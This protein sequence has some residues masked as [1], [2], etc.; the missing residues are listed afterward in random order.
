[1]KNTFLSLTVL[2]LTATGSCP[3]DTIEL[4]NG[5]FIHGQ[6]IGKLPAA[7]RVKVAFTGG[8]SITLEAAKIRRV[9]RDPSCDFKTTRKSPAGRI[10][11]RHRIRL[12]HGRTL[13]ADVV[14][15]PA[16][17]KP[18][19]PVELRLEG[20]GSLFLKPRTID[21]ITE[22]PGSYRIGSTGGK[23]AP[24]P[25]K[26]EEKKKPEEKIPGPGGSER[27]RVDAKVE[28]EILK[29][30][31]E[32]SRQ[33]TSNRVRAEASL[34][35]LGPVALPYLEK[36]ARHPFALT[37]RA[38]IRIVA[39]AG[40]PGGAGLLR[41]ALDDEDEWVRKLAREALAKAGG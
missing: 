29:A 41:A 33:R 5:R 24:S 30:V 3:A 27:A 15:S 19:K 16:A 28:A 26:P 22:K 35:R 32:L 31:S 13:A 4:Q 12:R 11:T 25:Q 18:G 23:P 1:M 8:G 17:A 7:G 6:V 39:E 21:S 36:A 9:L 2:L 10:D 37:R 34:K 40:G 20:I 14:E 38:V